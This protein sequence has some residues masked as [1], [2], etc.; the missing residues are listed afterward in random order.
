MNSLNKTAKILG[1][2]IVLTAS[3]ITSAATVSSSA[4]VTVNNVITLTEDV[5]LN[6]GSVRASADLVA[7]AGAVLVLNSDTN[8]IS[9]GTPVGTVVTAELFSLST[10]NAG[11]YTISDAARSGKIQVSV[12]YSL[13]MYVNKHHVTLVHIPPT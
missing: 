6:F 2:T 9:G 7:G 4:T 1:V 3:G 8:V 5:A 11:S 12:D 10:G 13:L